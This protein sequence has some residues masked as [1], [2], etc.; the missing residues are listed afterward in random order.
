MCLKG[1]VGAGECS[2]G[3]GRGK[4]DQIKQGPGVHAQKFGPVIGIGGSHYSGFEAGERRDQIC[5][6]EH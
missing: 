2:Q 3:R 1:R 4:Q 6:F 5:L